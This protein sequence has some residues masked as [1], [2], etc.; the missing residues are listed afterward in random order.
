MN[1]NE[2]VKALTKLVSAASNMI[3]KLN[4]NSFVNH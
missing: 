3:Y 2:G 4:F 1:L